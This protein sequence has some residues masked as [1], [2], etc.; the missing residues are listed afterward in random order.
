MGMERIPFGWYLKNLGWLAALGFFAGA[1][2]F[3]FLY[4]LIA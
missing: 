2:T 1:F 3:L 4:P